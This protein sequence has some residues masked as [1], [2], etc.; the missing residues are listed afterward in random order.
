[1]N[2]WIWNTDKFANRRFLMQENYQKYLEGDEAILKLRA[3]QDPFWEPIEDLFIGISN[4]FIQSLCYCMD[5]EE[6]AFIIDYK[7]NEV[8]TLYI[9]VIPCSKDGDA[10]GENAYVDDSKLLINKPFYFKVI[11]SYITTHYCIT[12]IYPSYQLIN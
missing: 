10:L 5:F 9:N 11:S 4:F 12:T 8:G 6:K 3:E 1:M 2:A 7:G